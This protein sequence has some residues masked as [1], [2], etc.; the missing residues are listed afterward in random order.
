MLNEAGMKLAR[1]TAALC[2]LLQRQESTGRITLGA[3]LREK[4]EAMEV[5]CL[6]AYADA[7]YVRELFLIETETPDD[8]KK[9]QDLLIDFSDDDDDDDDDDL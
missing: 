9:A 8:R 5:A 1:D 2:G 6:T 3:W 4:V 7:V